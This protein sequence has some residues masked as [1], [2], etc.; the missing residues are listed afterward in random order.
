[1][2]KQIIAWTWERFG[3]VEDYAQHGNRWMREVGS[4]P[5][6]FAEDIRNIQPLG[7]IGFK[8]QP[9]DKDSL[10][11]PAEIKKAILLAIAECKL[12]YPED[13]QARFSP[14]QLKSVSDATYM[15]LGDAEGVASVF[16]DAFDMLFYQEVLVPDL[17]RQAVLLGIC[18]AYTEYDNEMHEYLS[19]DEI[20]LAVVESNLIEDT[21]VE[22]TYLK[23]FQLLTLN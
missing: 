7:V 19:Y 13:I 9:E 20:T 16:K 8:S 5:P 2:T 4:H 10:P 21:H 14:E 23:A 11:I 17:I 15:E 22:D 18:E 1:M 12:K 3:N 6:Q